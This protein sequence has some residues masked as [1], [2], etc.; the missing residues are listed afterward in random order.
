MDVSSK[1]N[2]YHST[3]IRHQILIN[4]IPLSALKER[5]NTY[6]LKVRNRFTYQ[7][8]VVKIS[9][10]QSIIHEEQDFSYEFLTIKFMGKY[11]QIAVNKQHAD[12]E[13]RKSI[14]HYKMKYRSKHEQL[15]IE[16]KS[17][18]KRNIYIEEIRS[19]IKKA[20]IEEIRLE[21]QKQIIDTAPQK[22]VSED[23]VRPGPKSL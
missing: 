6:T 1:I 18:F 5:R 10:D 20:K 9:I 8:V 12:Q 7:T 2:I 22:S 14:G 23:S 19:R 3:D 4:R 17:R 21:K 15:E 11:L 16:V 13:L